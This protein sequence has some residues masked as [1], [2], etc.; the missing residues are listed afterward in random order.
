MVSEKPPSRKCQKYKLTLQEECRQRAPANIKS[1]KAMT[2]FGSLARQKTFRKTEK[3]LE[4]T[5]TGHRLTQP[6]QACLRRQLEDDHELANHNETIRMRRRMLIFPC[7]FVA[8][9]IRLF[10]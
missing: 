2:L 7:K 9:G 6:L 1:M 4:F 5:I 10:I 8:V 3:I